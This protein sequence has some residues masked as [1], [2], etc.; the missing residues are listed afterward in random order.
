MN[1]KLNYTKTFIALR[2]REGIFDM[3]GG[4]REDSPEE[5]TLSRAS[6]GQELAKRGVGGGAFGAGDS[7]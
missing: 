4:V 5:V 2:G 7:G 6:K 1:T 3:V